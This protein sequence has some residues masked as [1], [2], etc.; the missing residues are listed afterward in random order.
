M[1]GVWRARQDGRKQENYPWGES[2]A[3]Q[4]LYPGKSVSA[5][6]PQHFRVGLNVKFDP[7]IPPAKPLAFWCREQAMAWKR[8]DGLEGDQLRDLGEVIVPPHP[9]LSSVKAGLPPCGFGGAR[10]TLG[11]T[12]ESAL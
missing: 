3:L 7:D 11:A 1:A 12:H 5:A 9:E 10:L 2:Q 8:G 6:S 4:H